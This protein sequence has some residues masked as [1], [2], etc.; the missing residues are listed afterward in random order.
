MCAHHKALAAGHLAQGGGVLHVHVDT[1]VHDSLDHGVEL[2]ATAAG[3]WQDAVGLG[4][5]LGVVG[6]G[7]ALGA[8]LF[9]DG[10]NAGCAERL[11]AA[12]LAL[13]TREGE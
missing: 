3:I 13:Q 10:L 9:A 6:C 11:V 7:H 8:L 1:L 5:L 12:L 4:A 2:Q